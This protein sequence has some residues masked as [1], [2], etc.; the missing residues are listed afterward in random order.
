MKSAVLTLVTALVALSP[1]LAGC[2]E[3][4][5]DRQAAY[6]Q[7]IGYT[8]P[9]SKPATS[10]TT[11]V[12][13]PTSPPPPPPAV[14]PP[15]PQAGGDDAFADGAQP[16]PG[17]DYADTDPSALTDFRGALDPYGNWVEDPTYG[18]MWVPSESVVG[19]DFMP[20]QTAGHWNYDDEYTWVSDYDW[21][22]APFHYGRW[23]YEAPYGWSWIPGRTYAGAWV[24]W[25]YG[26]GDWGYVGWA[27]LGPTWGWRGGTAFGLGFV[28]AEP[29][30][31]CA[32]GDLFASHVS[33]HMVAAGQVAT[34]GAHTRPYVAATPTVPGRVAAEPRVNGPGPQILGIPASA[35]AHGA[36]ANRGV[37]QA[38]AYA[39]AATATGLGAHE[40]ASFASRPQSSASAF[41]SNRSYGTSE[42][43]HFGGKLGSGF[44]GS[45]SNVRPSY[46]IGSVRGYG[47]SGGYSGSGYRGGAYGLYGGYGGRS[48]VTLGSG[49]HGYGSYGSYGGYGMHGGYGMPGVQG[50]KPGQSSSSSGKRASDEGYSG[51]SGGGGHGGGGS[52][53]G[54]GHG[55]GRR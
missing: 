9:S 52:R 43:S 48:S 12:A 40:P 54:G 37:V 34:V 51:Y 33:P 36:L 55:G 4:D 31:F 27:P 39:S 14:I 41:A 32:T 49:Y 26:Y 7:P 45:I 22:W 21:G 24:S 17:Q 6:P 15:P 1:L 19:D 42:P 5:I 35:V 29:Y 23:V 13:A 20:Y 10:P 28:P 16:G 30:G 18:T 53:G 11:E 47:S 8:V 2:G 44:S 3:D 50:A 46:A 38:R 25:R